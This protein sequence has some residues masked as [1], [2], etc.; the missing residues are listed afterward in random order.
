MAVR[1]DIAY[2]LGSKDPLAHKNP[3]LLHGHFSKQLKT[4]G[5]A[6]GKTM[7]QVWLEKYESMLHRARKEPFVEHNKKIYG[8]LPIWV[9]IEVWDFGLMSKMYAG[10]KPADQDVIAIKYGARSGEAFADWL[11]SF[12]F[13]RNV[14]AHHSRLWNINILERSPV[15]SY[16]ESYDLNNAKPFLYFCLMK[17]M[18]SNICPNSSWWSRLIDL[19]ES[20]PTDPSASIQL[21]DFGAVKGWRDWNV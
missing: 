7:H 1:V 8:D 21:E 10:M 16:W 17:K 5:A 6:K 3:N 18:L 19:T 20:F 15:P 9:A 14:S 12:N 11:R 4:K 2:L 13:I